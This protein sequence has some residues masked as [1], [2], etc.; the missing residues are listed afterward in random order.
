[1][2]KRL[3]L[4]GQFRD[5]FNYLRECKMYIFFILLLFVFSAFF[6]FRYS[7]KLTFI[8]DLLKDIISQTSDLNAGEMIFFI[9][10][11]NVQSAF[12]GMIFGVFFGIFS[13]I[14]SL[15]NGVV[16]G[17]VL[18]KIYPLT[19]FSEFWRLLPHGI[20]EL[21]AIF[22][23]LGAGLRLGGVLFSGDIKKQ[24][25]IR[26]YNSLNLFLM[27]IL[28]LLIVAAVIEGILIFLI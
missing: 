17:Y 21:P 10:Q 1:M 19:G 28:P 27:I 12:F 3:D 26:I 22:I 23:S 20:F 15:L 5:A 7:E 11:N 4:R 9:L 13:L 8:D 24:F 6:G 14:N 18:A 16:L 2:K 25:K